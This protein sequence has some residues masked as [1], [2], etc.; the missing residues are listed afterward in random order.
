MQLDTWMGSSGKQYRPSFILTSREGR[1]S[2]S[3]SW[4]PLIHTLKKQKK[5]LSKNKTSSWS[6]LLS[7]LFPL[8][9]FPVFIPGASGRTLSY[10]SGQ[11]HFPS[12]FCSFDWPICM[13]WSI[14]SVYINHKFCNVLHLYL[15][16]EVVCSYDVLTHN[17]STHKNINIPITM[18]TT[19]VTSK[20]YNQ[21]VLPNSP[22]G[23]PLPSL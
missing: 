22:W 23:G 9:S 10:W 16:M 20:C 14:S 18:K 21:I 13:T 17:A 5:I 15:M 6:L 7:C 8:F 1:V 2:P 11:L 19:D 12:S 4:Q 3:T